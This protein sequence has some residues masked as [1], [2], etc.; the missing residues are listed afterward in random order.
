MEICNR[1]AIGLGVLSGNV[2]RE[3]R[4]SKPASDELERWVRG[5]AS[6][7]TVTAK[8]VRSYVRRSRRITENLKQQIAD[9]SDELRRRDQHFKSAQAEHQSELDVVRSGAASAHIV[10]EMCIIAVL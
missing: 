6:G 10:R 7:L 1:C 8:E 2:G 9:L 4:E 3:S 5:D